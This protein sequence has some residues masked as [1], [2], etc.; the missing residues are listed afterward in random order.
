MPPTLKGRQTEAAFLDAARRM[1]AEKGFLNTKI[2]DIAAAAGRSTGSFYNYYESKERLLEALLEQFT[3]EIVDGSLRTRHADAEAGVRAAVTAYW[4]TYRKYLPE[5]IGLFQMSMLDETF[6]NRWRT[7]RTAG[8]RQILTGLQSAQRAGHPI[9]LPLRPLA[10]ALV[11]VLE[12]VCWTWLVANGDA[13]ESPPDD[14]TAIDI[15]TA[16]WFRT[17]YQPGAVAG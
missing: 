15:L 14:E 1:F 16:I 3:A 4:T 13:D 12:S 2:S 7:N 8:I 5:M 10:T 9:G 11:S 6:A 17:V